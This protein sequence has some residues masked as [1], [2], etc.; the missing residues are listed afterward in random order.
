MGG[1]KRLSPHVAGHIR[2]LIVVIHVNLAF[3]N[4]QRVNVYLALCWY[5]PLAQW[6]HA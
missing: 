2:A 6:P 4:V 3:I 5:E 1:L